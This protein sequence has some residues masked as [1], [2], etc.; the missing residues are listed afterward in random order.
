MTVA[1]L[2]VV[3]VEPKREADACV[4][5]LHGLGADG[6]DFVNVIPNLGLSKNHGIRF[7]FPH[8]PKQPVTINGGLVMPAWY[9]IAAIDLDSAQDEVGL[10]KS[11]MALR[12]LLHQQTEQGI[13]SDR[14]VLMGF[15]QGGALA[16]HTALRLDKPLAG[17]GV[18]S[19]Y[20][21]LHQ[22]VEEEQCVENDT[23][24]IFMAHGF[25]DPV[26]P[27]WIGQKSFAMLEKLG[28]EPTWHAYAMPHTVCLQE[29][30]DIGQW[31]RSVLA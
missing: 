1:L 17:V 23:I 16:L 10:K 25:M 9:D 7:I 20:L 14:I 21:P 13:Y 18:L 31:L 19:S 27:Y 26:V 6:H 11:E 2:D 15:S 3:K 8:A 24:S 5:W 30:S 28:Y 29:L 22:Q 12:G 4:I